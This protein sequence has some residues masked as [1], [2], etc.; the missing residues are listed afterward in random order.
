[1]RDLS[2]RELLSWGWKLGVGLVAIAG[3][4]TTWDVLRP[5][6]SAGIGGLIRTLP[7]AAVPGDE[8]VAV[9]AA[10]SYLTRDETGV[11]AISE[12]CPH[13]GCRVDW[14]DS[15]RQFECAC[16]GSTFNRLGEYRT[17]PSPRGMDRHP[18]VVT[19]GVVEVDTGEVIAGAAPGAE[20]I[21]EPPAG[22]SCIEG[23]HH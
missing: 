5:R 15:S 21:D 3:G 1:M 9:L 2:R 19:N 11:V 18:V 16:H 7:E 13:L 22:P 10:R 4:W 20:S 6:L 8:A 12:I 17:G 23:T 14:C